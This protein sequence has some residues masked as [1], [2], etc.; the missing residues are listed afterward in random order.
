MLKP[1]KTL[2]EYNEALVKFV[3]MPESESELLGILIE[4][5]E[6]KTH[7]SE[8]KAE[9]DEY[10]KIIDKYFPDFKTMNAPTWYLL[11]RMLNV[12]LGEEEKIKKNQK[13]EP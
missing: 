8:I 5:Y 6:R 12:I 9:L 3:E 1:I 11:D 4:S 2:E 13:N 7:D 10:H